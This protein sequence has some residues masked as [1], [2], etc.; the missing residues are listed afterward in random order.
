MYQQLQPQAQDGKGASW[1]W[2]LLGGGGI[3]VVDALFL[4]FGASFGLD[5]LVGPLF[6]ISLAF[7]LGAGIFA[8]EAAGKVRAGAFAG[9]IAG[10]IAPV[11]EIILLLVLLV[12]TLIFD[13]LGTSNPL[14]NFLFGGIILAL[15]LGPSFNLISLIGLGIVVILRVVLG[16]GLGA[17]GAL[18]GR[19]FY[20]PPE[21][22]PAE[23]EMEDYPARD[24][25]QPTRYYIPGGQYFSQQPGEDGYTD[26]R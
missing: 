19:G 23:Y 17:L 1:R 6:L 5:S 25:Y 20:E 3:A 7:L 24:V 9:A 4:W 10:I 2:G 12:V 16:L 8:G 14:Q 21:E 22:E 18:I 11:A 26:F 13:V 15:L